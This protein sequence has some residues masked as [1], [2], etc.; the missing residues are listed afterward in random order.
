MIIAATG[1]RPPNLGG[2]GIEVQMKTR[3]LAREYLLEA[4]PS[5][6]ITGMALGWDQAVA[7]AAIDLRI[8]FHAYIPFKGQETVWPQAS[9]LY[10]LELLKLSEHIE[11]CSD[12][13]FSAA[14]MSQ[15]NRRMVDA[16]DG[17]VA[18]WDGSSGGTCNCIG[19]A[20]FAGKPYENLWFKFNEY[21]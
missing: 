6:V 20:T 3:K 5:L 13:G 11:V 4:K 14:A 15:R 21:Q 7:K 18:L 19:Y 1:H 10:Y 17:L 16:C 12:G 2:Y 9:R 8:P